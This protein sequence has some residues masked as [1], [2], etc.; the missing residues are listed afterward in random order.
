MPA[1]PL[2]HCLDAFLGERLPA[3]TLLPVTGAVLFG[4]QATSTHPSFFPPLVATAPSTTAASVS[5]IILQELNGPALQKRALVASVRSPTGRA[6][7]WASSRG[8]VI[9]AGPGMFVMP[10]EPGCLEERQAGAVG[11]P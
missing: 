10:E 7:W 11:T 5:K 3:G 1:A 6:W 8:L 9:I 4:P 2:R